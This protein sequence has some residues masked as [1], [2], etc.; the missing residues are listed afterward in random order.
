MA[1]PLV[2]QRQEFGRRVVTTPALVSS[3]NWTPGDVWLDGSKA[4]HYS[5]GLRDVG[6]GVQVN[7]VY[8]GSFEFPCATGVVMAKD[9]D[10]FYDTIN[11]TIVAAG[12]ANI[13]LVG[14]LVNAKTSGQL[15]ALVQ[16][17]NM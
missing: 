9:A 11:R 17:N 16:L 7:V 13:I 1:L 6:A 12:G 14:K 8:V 10:A 15:T 5:E 3:R 4:V 2:L